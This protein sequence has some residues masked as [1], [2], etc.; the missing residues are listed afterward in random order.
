MVTYSILTPDDKKLYYAVFLRDGGKLRLVYVLPRGGS[1]ARSLLTFYQVDHN[2]LIRGNEVENA[3]DLIWD[4]G[5]QW[6]GAVLKY[7]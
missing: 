4:V 1:A 2:G 5:Y 7:N 3:S 6:Q